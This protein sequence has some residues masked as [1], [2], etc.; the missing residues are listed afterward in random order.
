MSAVHRLDSDSPV[1]SM[2]ELMSFCRSRAII[3]ESSG[4]YGGAATTYDFGPVGAQLKKN[5]VDMWWRDFVEN[6]D[7][8]AP[9]DTG[10][11]LNPAG[12]LHG[13][14]QGCTNQGAFGVR[15]RVSE[16]CRRPNGAQPR[17]WCR[18]TSA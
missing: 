18:L 17:A 9:L 13:A 4:V 8:V 11:I 16:V 3:L 10:V 12:S 2:E 1:A 14:G 5:I 15:A 7:D 6:R